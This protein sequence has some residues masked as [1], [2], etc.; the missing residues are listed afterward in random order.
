ML[1]SSC[2]SWP[3]RDCDTFRFGLQASRF[4][5]GVLPGES[6]TA[7]TAYQI[8]YVDASLGTVLSSASGT[9][10]DTAPQKN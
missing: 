1:P 4:A 2:V 5:S 7:F 9:V 10:H 8:R 3:L 6:S